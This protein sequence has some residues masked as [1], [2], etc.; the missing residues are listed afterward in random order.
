MKRFIVLLAILLLHVPL[1]NNSDGVT[2]SSA[3]CY[4]EIAFCELACGIDRTFMYTRPIYRNIGAQLSLWHDFVFNACSNIDFSFQVMPMY[5]QSISSSGPT[6]YFL[7]DNKTFL[8]VKGD[9]VIDN[10]PFKRDIRAEWLKLPSNFDGGFTVKPSQKQFGLWIEGKMNLRTCFENEFF[11]PFWVGF[12]LPFQMIEN[13]IHLIETPPTNPGTTFP[14]NITEALGNPELEYVRFG[15]KK[16]RTSLAEINLRLGTNFLDSDGFQIGTYSLLAIPT[17]SVNNPRFVFSPFLGNNCAVGM[18]QGVTF[19]LPLN[20]DTHCKLFAFFFYIEN[21]Y[22]IR[23]FQHRTLDLKLKPYS[24]YLLFV[25]R[26]GTRNIPGPTVLTRTMRVRPYIMVDMS[27][28][29]RFQQNGFECEIS[30]NLWARG[31][32]R[33]KLRYCLPEDFGIQGEGFIQDTGIPATASM[34]TIQEQAPNDVQFNLAFQFQDP[35]EIFVPITANDLQFQSAAAQGGLNH[36]AQFACGKL[37]ATCTGEFF[38]GFGGYGEFPQFNSDL[39]RWGV[40]AKF[41]FAT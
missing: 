31:E 33:A 11:H 3:A 2:F 34:S 32:E 15:P 4:E 1:Y 13:N 28:G 8:T 29:F 16:R 36:R 7:F 20:L 10:N 30:Y 37:W 5:G 6:R 19:Q 23:N 27:T 17:A 39:N 18:G 12:A 9:D 38:L 26:D 22:F 41:G 14:R 21:I 40:W 35:K 25:N 24:R